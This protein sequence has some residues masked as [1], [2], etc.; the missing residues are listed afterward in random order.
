MSMF[1]YETHLHTLPVSAC[2][3]ASV[4]ENL[5][6][7]KS[8][9][10]AGVFITNHFLDSNIGGDRSLPYSE[11]IE[12]FIH[13]YTEAVG[14]GKEIG[15]QVFFGVELSYKGTDFLIYGL[16]PDWYRAHPEIMDMDKRTE[17]GFMQEQGALV[18]HAH[19]FREAD[20]IDHIRLYPRSCQAV[21]ILNSCRTPLENKMAEIYAR[22]YGFAVTAG[23]D[24]HRGAGMRSLAGMQLERPL[25]SELDYKEAVLSGEARIFTIDR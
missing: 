23:T 6:F 2:A 24:N 18:V 1:R 25:T 11:Q 7:Y 13:D 9:D 21:E 3:K 22:E 5:E 4:R 8:L 14:I 15:L 20:Y 16:S 19:P 10:Y 12:F 17:L